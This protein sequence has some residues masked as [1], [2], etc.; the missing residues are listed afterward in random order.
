MVVRR[1][2]VVL[3]VVVLACL[4]CGQSSK[5][6]LT[7]DQVMAKAR[8]SVFILNCQTPSGLQ[9]ATAFLIDSSGLAVAPYS[10]I[11][12]TV[13][14]TA[15]FSDGSS[16][17]V[18]GI[19][20]YDKLYDL[21]LIKVNVSNRP[22]LSISSFPPNAGAK[23][24][25]LGSSNG[26]AITLY[27]NS[28]KQVINGSRVK[29]VWLNGPTSTYNLGGPVVNTRGDVIGA[30]AYYHTSP[31]RPDLAVSIS[32]LKSLNRSLALK[33]FGRDIVATNRKPSQTTSSSS[34]PLPDL[35]GIADLDL[36]DEDWQNFMDLSK[37]M[38]DAS[39][40]SY[41]VCEQY[42][43]NLQPTSL[44]FG[45][46]PSLY[47]NEDLMKTER[48]QLM[49]VTFE[50]EKLEAAR[51][52]VVSRIGKVIDDSDEMVALVTAAQLAGSWSDDALRTSESLQQDAISIQHDDAIRA[53]IQNK[54]YQDMFPKYYLELM[55]V[56]PTSSGFR[57]GILS[58]S[59]DPL[60]V[61]WAD[62][63]QAA[64]KLKINSLDRIL[65]IDGVAPKD[66]D[67][68][69]RMVK[70]S[71]GRKVII[72]VAPKFG[73]EREYEVEVPSHLGS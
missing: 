36:S 40:C 3:I 39:D 21:A 35:S 17:K 56:I 34:K 73:D 42:V 66:M 48:G 58:M 43:I 70:Q 47:E 15:K 38:V 26:T 19:V 28:I 13:S 59:S 8:K 72:R 25:T 64:G 23:V 20:D 65:S 60:F 67:D 44:A 57:M 61:I 33:P 24:F 69:K 51:Q 7:P 53:I 2:S 11:E 41:G 62:P 49:S 29:E 71:E 5:R 6:V 63:D 10:V 31:D 18:A 16:Y 37:D 14:A 68:F 1:L 22:G 12:T 52:A 54:N 27:T 30:I 9:A 32:Y 45:V 50:N 4:A 55:G 46:F